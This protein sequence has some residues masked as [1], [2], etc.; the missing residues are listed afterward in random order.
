[1]QDGALAHHLKM[2]HGATKDPDGHVVMHAHDACFQR[3]WMPF[4]V[5]EDFFDLE[6]AVYLI[7]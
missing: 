1:M 5:E 4:C 7:F 6:G 2:V 3:G